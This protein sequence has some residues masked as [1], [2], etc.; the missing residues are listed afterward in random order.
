MADRL[1]LGVIGIGMAWGQLHYPALK[2]LS[3][4][5]EIVAVCNKT[6][7][8]AQGFARGI[9]LA[10]E[11]VYSDYKQLLARSD[12]DVVDVL[13]PISENFEVA[14]DVLAAGK[15]LIA[16]KPFASTPQ[17][18]KELIAL[19]NKNNCKVLV[20]ENFRYDEGNQL[21]KQILSSGAIGEACY[22]IYNTAADF[23]KSMTGNTFAAKEWRQYPAF[24]GGIFLDGGIHEIALMRYLFGDAKRVFALGRPQQEDYCPYVSITS[25]IEFENS[26]TGSFCYFTKGELQKPPVGLRIFGTLGEIFLES[27]DAGVVNIN[28]ADGRSEQ[29]NY[30]ANRGYYNELLNFFQGDLVSTPEKELGDLSLV[31]DILDSVQTGT[32]KSYSAAAL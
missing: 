32:V 13:V 5:Y 20:A 24:R 4:Q 29:R 6:I 19:K 30:A 12:I 21:I 22:F 3:E 10:E 16:E 1:R 18:A 26:V 23:D 28:Y 27:K 14:R 7:D 17:A 9:G 11:H 2:E 8:K 31:F 25:L 15:D